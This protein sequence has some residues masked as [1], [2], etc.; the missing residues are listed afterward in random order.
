MAAN[1]GDLDTEAV[2]V[3]TNNVEGVGAESFSTDAH[4]HLEQKTK[5]PAL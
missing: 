1:L 2:D 4:L 5:R 3:Q